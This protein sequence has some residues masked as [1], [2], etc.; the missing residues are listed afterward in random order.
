VEEGQLRSADGTR[1]FWRREAAQGKARA[2]VL[3]VHGFAEHSGRY[4]HVLRG[5]AAKSFDAWALDLRGHGRSD[6]GRGCI[7]RWSDYL[8]DLAGLLALA[9]PDRDTVPVFLL[10]H[11]MGGLVATRFCQERPSGVRGLL[12]S[13][14]FFRVKMPVP[15]VKRAA[16]R[17]LSSVIPNLAIPSGL[18]ANLVS[19]DP[20]V[21]KAYVEDPLVFHKATTRWFTEATGAQARAFE[22]ASA[23]RLPVLLIHGAA[24]GLVDPEASREIFER[25]GSPDKTLK[26]WP[27]L[28]HEILNEPEKETVL[29][30]FV[31]WIEKRLV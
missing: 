7:S 9:A 6:G 5:L 13:S 11:S 22:E 23:L 1:L 28:R 21:V 16:G 2:R 20:A 12:L 8:E 30:T 19:R 4:G 15:L 3:V 18:D 14:P 29:A 31:E 26:L 17:V 10:G 25:L 27:E 24:D